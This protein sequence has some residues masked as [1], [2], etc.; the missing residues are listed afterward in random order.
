[1]TLEYFDYRKDYDN[2]IVTPEIRARFM[3]LEPNRDYTGHTHD[4]GHEIFAV[5]DGEIDFDIAG[6]KAR[7]GPGQMCVALADETHHLRVVGDQPAIIYLS[8]TPHIHP[9]HTFWNADG[10]KAPWRYDGVQQGWTH[11]PATPDLVDAQVAA[12]RAL[13]EA[14]QASLDAHL[15]V[16][17]DLKAALTAGDAPGAR[18]ALDAMWAGVFASFK[19]AYARAAT[20]NELAPRAAPTST[21]SPGGRGQ[22]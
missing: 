16:Q 19:S 11:A 22:R 6:R 7:L 5:V 17:A 10:T 21:P 15:A 12:A 20:W 1:M 8:V 13:A 2:P 9:T 4:L 14:A 18:A 3:K